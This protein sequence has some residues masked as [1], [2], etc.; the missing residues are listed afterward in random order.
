MAGVRG[1][2]ELT[3]LF[4]QV[5]L[6]AHLKA[7]GVY[8][9]LAATD[10]AFDHLSAPMLRERENNAEFRRRPVQNHITGYNRL[11]VPGGNMVATLGM[12]ATGRSWAG[13]ELRIGDGNTGPPRV[14]NVRVGLTDIPAANGI[15]HTPENCMAQ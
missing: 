6:E 9:S 7:A 5:G 14:N 15:V 4:R 12:A 2:P 8:G 1:L 3:A 11:L 10:G 13:Q